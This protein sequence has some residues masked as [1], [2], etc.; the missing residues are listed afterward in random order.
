MIRRPGP[1]GGPGRIFGL[2]RPTTWPKLSEHWQ[3]AALW[4]RKGRSPAKQETGIT[5][6]GATD[7]NEF[8]RR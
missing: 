8:R 3:Q 5:G 2:S 7:G 6:K 1:L 4:G